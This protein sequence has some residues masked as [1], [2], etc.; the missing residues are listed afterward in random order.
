MLKNL[1]TIGFYILLAI[2]L[3][4]LSIFFYSETISYF[5][6]H[7]HAWTQSDRY[8]IALM[9]LQEGFNFFKP[10]TYNLS[11]I[12]GITGVDLPIHEFL[13]ALIMKT[14]GIDSPIVFRIY[15]LVFSFIGY[16]FLFRLT[17][18][19]TGS[20]LK[21]LVLVTFVFTCPIITYYQAGFI[22][23]STSFSTAIIAYYFYFKFKKERQ[24][25]HFYYSVILMTLAALTRTPFN[26]FLFAIFLQ[27]LWVYVRE[28]RVNWNHIIAFAL[29][30][31]AIILYNLYKVYLNNTYGTQFLTYLLPARSIEELVNVFR[32]VRERWTFQLFSIY[33]Y[34]LLIFAIASVSFS[35]I[36]QKHFTFVEKQILLNVMISMSGAALY[37]I[38][39]ARQFVA[40]EYYFMDTFY[41][42]IFLFLILGVK[43]ISFNSKIKKAFWLL[44]FTGLLIGGVI[45]SKSVQNLKYSET[46]WDRG[47][48]TRK[49]FIDADKFLD[50]LNISRDEKI[51]VIDAYSTNAP[52]ILMGRR[53][54]TV[55]IKS[56]EK[57]EKGLQEDFDYI[58]IQ[59]IF[60]PSEV[61]FPYPEILSQ[62]ERIG[63]NGKISVFKLNPV[64]YDRK[65]REILGIVEPYR[66]VEL[67]FD[68]T[69]SSPE[70]S[71]ID[72]I[73]SVKF[74]S[75][76]NS[77][78][79][80]DKTEF[81]PT[82]EI[83]IGQNAFNKL[84]F[85]G[86][87]LSPTCTNNHR[88]VVAISDNEGLVYYWEFPLNLKYQKKGE[89][90]RYQC[91]FTLPD[92]IKS[93]STLKWYF[94][95]PGYDKIYLDDIKLTLYKK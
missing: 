13:V 95:N 81:G 73:S 55:H 21:S 20:N 86:Y 68:T 9:F 71:N 72:Q 85:E 69:N 3:T 26:I 91:L 54:Y 66:I 89:W 75:A 80:D 48:V 15:T 49:N 11:T 38:L 41:L 74:H 79:I 46:L 34:F 40:H 94:W 84:L 37:F 19:I 83:A 18:E 77:F 33:H 61:V 27:Q 29:A 4:G 36:K 2:V 8:A 50:E 65:L 52:L 78:F 70:W 32:L 31:G 25:R 1:N 42:P 51:L 59:D 62:I 90:F 16:L 57:I 7:I 64:D 92:N 67:D 63:G 35:I 30:Y 24:S 58:V 10:Q 6:S 76:P 87:L 43:G 44:T 82:L 60:I 53:G 47:E 5:P 88:N 22:P 23:S 45:E 17:N 28:K 93:G 56:R 39:M 14:I 12:E